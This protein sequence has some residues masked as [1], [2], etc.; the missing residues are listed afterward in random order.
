M[1]PKLPCIKHALGVDDW[2]WI[3]LQEDCFSTRLWPVAQLCVERLERREHP[4]DVVGAKVEA[5]R[6]FERRV[7][8]LVPEDR[9]AD[10]F[11]RDER[12]LKRKH[13]QIAGDDAGDN[14][15]DI[16]RGTWAK[17]E[18][19]TWRAPWQV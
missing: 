4:L 9:R 12:R 16:A 17:W 2:G 10:Q 8:L 11:R 6:L 14:A 1:K 3:D 5:R 7:P 18:S 19:V 13:Q 15:G